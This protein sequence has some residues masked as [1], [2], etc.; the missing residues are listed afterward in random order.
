[1][2]IINFLFSNWDNYLVVGLYALIFIAF[3]G[4]ILDKPFDFGG[5]IALIIFSIFWPI[6][7]PI[8]LIAFVKD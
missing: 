5:L 3:I 6:G 4:F 8:M 1:M 2:D 7:L